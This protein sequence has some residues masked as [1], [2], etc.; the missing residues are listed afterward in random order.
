MKAQFDDHPLAGATNATE[1]K[2]GREDLIAF[3]RRLQKA[4]LETASLNVAVT[5][6]DAAW[7]YAKGYYADAP[8]EPMV[9]FIA[10]VDH[11]E[12]TAGA[13]KR[14]PMDALKI[15]EGGLDSAVVAWEGSKNTSSL[16]VRARRGE[17]LVKL[18]QPTGRGMEPPILLS[19]N[20]AANFLVSEIHRK[21]M[22]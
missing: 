16:I 14:S 15:T 6:R 2:Q 10:Y 12:L 13:R 9:R 20:F 3:W 4:A 18:A 19:Q 22:V 7:L 11:L 1:S 21:K 5:L 17:Q 8:V